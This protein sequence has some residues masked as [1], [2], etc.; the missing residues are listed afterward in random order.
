MSLTIA[1]QNETNSVGFKIPT[2]KEV[3]LIVVHTK[4]IKLPIFKV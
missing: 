1:W 4:S 2:S 3:W